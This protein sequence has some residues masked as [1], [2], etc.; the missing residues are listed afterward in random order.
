MHVVDLLQVARNKK[1]EKR[2]PQGGGVGG[3]VDLGEE[4]EKKGRKTG[5]RE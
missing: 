4:T 5:N 2:F 1:V 3:R